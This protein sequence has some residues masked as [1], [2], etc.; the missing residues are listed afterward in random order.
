MDAPRVRRARV[1]PRRPEQRLGKALSLQLTLD[2]SGECGEVIAQ[3]AATDVL[4]RHPQAPT[5]CDDVLERRLVHAT[6]AHSL[7]PRS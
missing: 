6:G 3:I 2:C 5:C 7:R 4:T 1:N